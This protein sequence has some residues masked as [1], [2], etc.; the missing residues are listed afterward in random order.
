MLGQTIDGNALEGVSSTTLYTLY[1]R[2]TFAAGDRRVVDDPM[3][4][5]IFD[6]IDYDWSKFGKADPA[7]ALRSR[8]FD[9]ATRDFL[10]LNPRA[11]IVALGEG[12]QTSYWRL[13]RP[14][15]PWFSIDLEPVMDL[16]S[17]VLPDEQ[18]IT[19]LAESAFDTA[20]MSSIPQGE[21]VFV[22]AEGLL[23][24]FDE[25]SAMAL[26]AE[27]AAR[28]PGGGM[29]FDSI[30]TWV[31]KKTIKGVAMSDHYTIPAMPFSMSTSRARLLASEIPGVVSATEKLFPSA[32]GMS[33][34]MTNRVLSDLPRLRDLRPCTTVLQFAG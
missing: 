4:L 26:I 33:K 8:T 24:Y 23:M 27:C 10:A 6:S 22:T 30:P 29:I 13:G 11:T 12:L 28:F 9:R 17:R 1:N 21:K 14:H 19:H 32:H 15:N 5:R 16:R 2:A 31:S 25:A 3:A 34:F 7:A 20:W 18:E